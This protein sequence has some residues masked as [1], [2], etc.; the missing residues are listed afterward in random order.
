M[1]SPFI[2][3]VRDHIVARNYG[4]RTEQTY[5]YWILAYIRFHHRV[6]T[7]QLS[8][9]DVQAY[10]VL[11]RNVSEST[12]RAALDALIYLYKQF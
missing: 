5:I 8:E 7:E 1:G 4:K 11:K 6:H 9:A 10:L 3:A 12:Q 2:Q